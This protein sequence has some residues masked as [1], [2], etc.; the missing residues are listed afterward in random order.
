MTNTLEVVLSPIISSADFEAAYQKYFPRTV[1]HLAKLGAQRETAE[2]L[3]QSA[4]SRGWEYRH[5]LRDRASIHG[6]VTGIARNLFFESFRRKRPMETL[7]ETAAFTEPKLHNILLD[8]MLSG[9]DERDRTLL[10]ETY[11][12]GES[13]YDLGP[14]MGMTPVT[15]RVRLNRVKQHLRKFF[16]TQPDFPE[17]ERRLLAA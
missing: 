1:N 6:W 3:A 4:W 10:I 11:G 5:Q 16:G 14:R 9:I 7:K 17:S 8:Q 2:E 12:A 13:S 15:V